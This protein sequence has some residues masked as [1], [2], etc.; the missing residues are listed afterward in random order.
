MLPFGL[1]P[2]SKARIESLG[3]IVFTFRIWGSTPNEELAI[4]VFAEDMTT[5]R[6]FSN[7]QFEQFREG[8][9]IAFVP[10][11]HLDFIRGVIV[12]FSGWSEEDEERYSVDLTFVHR[13]FYCLAHEVDFSELRLSLDEAYEIIT[14]EF[15]MNFNGPFV[16]FASNAAFEYLR[17]KK[18]VDGKMPSEEEFTG[19]SFSLQELQDSIALGYQEGPE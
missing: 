7:V 15:F 17:F 18:A 11:N 14:K 8:N 2:E 19:S 9:I 4:E 13:G 6:R 16:S 1:T 10:T 12:D 5:L 3:E